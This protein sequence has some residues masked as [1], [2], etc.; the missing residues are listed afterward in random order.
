MVEAEEVGEFVG[1]LGAALH[2]VEQGELTVQQDLA[3]AGQVD[4][5]LGD[6]AA[7]VGLFDGGLD[8][9]ALQGV[10]GL[11]DL[12]ELVLPVFEA[13]RLGL[14]IDLLARGEPAH[15][16]G[17]PYARDLVRLLAD[18]A[19]VADEGAA[20]A[21][22]DDE[23]DGEG[24][25]AEDAGGARLEEDVVGDGLDAVLV[26]VGRVGAHPAQIV[27]DRDRRGL[28]A[29]GVDGPERL[30]GAGGED[31]LLDLLQGAGV[32]AAPEVLVDVLVGGGQD[33]E[34]GGVEDLAFGHPV[35]EGPDLLAA[36]GARGES[37]GEQGVLAGE[38]LARA[39]DADEGAA[40]LVHAGVL[41]RVQGAE[42][43]VVGVDEFVVAAQ[44]AVAG[45]GVVLDLAAQPGEVFEAV[46]DGGELVGG[47]GAHVAADP[48]DGTRTQVGGGL[49][50]GAAL[51]AQVFEGVGAAG[52]GQV[53]EG[54]AAFLLE[55]LGHV[56]G[57]V[58]ESAHHVGPG[59]ELSRFLAGD[60][61]GEGPQGRQRH[62][63][64][65]QQRHDLPADRLPAKAHGLP[66]VN[67]GARGSCSDN[68]R[69]E[70][71]TV[72]R[73]IRRRV[74]SLTPCDQRLWWRVVRR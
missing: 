40:L 34:V 29:L 60:H 22:G 67:P 36:H 31:A 14:D 11:S 53:D 70:P 2:G 55:G 47:F 4:E 5:H 23:G 24:D 33:R 63:R 39:G 69:R 46:L 56:L 15:H 71:T 72:G 62:Q 30:G 45:D 50:G 51:G 13:R 74:R 49:V 42:E 10:E 16:A 8:G 3:A 19:Q 68:K 44:R 26:A 38:G 41:E 32:V 58:A 35:G 66:N 7:H 52:V 25:E 20:D 28:P 6:A 37:G 59:Q 1:V 27:E 65:Q 9:G 18:P 21:G 54:L 64:H 48:A 43:R 73:P 57:G 12:A 61:G 17:Q